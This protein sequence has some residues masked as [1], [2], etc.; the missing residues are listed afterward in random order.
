M[1][2][3]RELCVSQLI[4]PT[5]EAIILVS[6]CLLYDLIVTRNEKRNPLQASV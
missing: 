6:L 3:I 4:E 1:S 2:K 5:L